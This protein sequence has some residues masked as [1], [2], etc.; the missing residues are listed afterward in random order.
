[1]ITTT[2]QKAKLLDLTTE[3]LELVRK[4]N[5]NAESVSAV[6]QI[7]KNDENFMARLMNFP[8]FSLD[9]RKEDWEL[10]KDVSEQGNVV[11]ADLEIVPF[12]RKGEREVSGEVLRSRAVELQADLGQRHAEYLL[13]HQAEIPKE[14]RKFCLLFPGT[15]WCD[16]NDYLYVPYLCRNDDKWILPFHYLGY[17]LDSS[18]CL[19]RPRKQ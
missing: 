16:R 4:G 19:I 11:I 6:L 7:I 10:V 15:V 13:E 14:F 5:R 8:I 1:M 2:E 9:M 18:Y 3:V 17:N 12:L